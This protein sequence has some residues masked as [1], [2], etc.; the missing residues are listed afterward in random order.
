MLITCLVNQEEERQ[1][2]KPPLRLPW[3]HFKGSGCVLCPP[4]P[5]G[6][7]YK[8]HCN[9]YWFAF[10]LGNGWLMVNQSVWKQLFWVFITWTVFKCAVIMRL[11]RG[12]LGLS[13]KSHVMDPMLG[14]SGDAWH[15]SNWQMT[16]L[17]IP[18]FMSCGKNTGKSFNVKGCSSSSKGMHFYLC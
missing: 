8:I 18:T 16:P 2:D 6:Q 15:Q 12:Q 9:C 10:M 5:H 14:E 1:G 17:L 4:W 3:L 13:P 7:W 11:C